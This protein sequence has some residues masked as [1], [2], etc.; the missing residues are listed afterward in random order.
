MLLNKR[1]NKALNKK[2]SAGNIVSTK[3]PVINSFTVSTSS[4]T[5]YEIDASINTNQLDVYVYVVYKD[6]SSQE[7]EVKI[8]DSPI[9]GE[10]ETINYTLN[11]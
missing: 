8:T 5:S 1:L 4:D 3:V 2:I 7:V 9:N 6:S 11:L 10:S